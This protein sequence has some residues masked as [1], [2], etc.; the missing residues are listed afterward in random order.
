MPTL[1]I[2]FCLTASGALRAQERVQEGDTVQVSGVRDP[3]WKTYANMLKGVQAFEEK[4]RLAPGAPLRFILLP[5][6]PDVVMRGLALKLENDTVRI[7]VELAADYTFELPRNQEA[8]DAGAD[9]TLNRKA[10]SVKWH[11]HIRSAG[12]LPSQRRLG[13]LRLECEM[14]WATDKA[15]L[16]LAM[17]AMVGLAGGPCGAS[18]L[19]FWFDEPK[20][21]ASATLVAGERR[22]ALQLAGGGMMF[23]PPLHDRSWSD[24]SLVELEFAPD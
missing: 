12:L 15:T 14:L 2:L 22:L 18:R 11:P 16:P 10:K 20:R 1:M 6:R 17:R 7:P 9:L 19:T 8:A 5:R 23:L 24:D 21:L 13:D 3:D 4:H